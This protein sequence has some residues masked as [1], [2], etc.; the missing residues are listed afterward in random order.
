MRT[1]KFRGWNPK[2][3]CWLY[4]FYLKNRG[5]HFIAEEGIQPPGRTWQDF[6][7]LPDTVGQFTGMV[8]V[9]GKDVFEGDVMTNDKGVKWEVVYEDCIGVF[10]AKESGGRRIRYISAIEGRVTGNIYE[11]T[12]ASSRLE[13]KG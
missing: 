10:H 12:I 13:I 5:Q 7:V 8:D 9:D 1:I 3:K 6:E 4:G 11:Q 2:N